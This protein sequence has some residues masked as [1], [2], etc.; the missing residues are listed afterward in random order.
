MLRLP[1]A[2]LPLMH[3]ILRTLVQSFI[4]AAAGVGTAVLGADLS[5]DVLARN[6]WMELTRAD[7]DAVVARVPEDMRFEFSTSPRRVQGVLNNLLVTKTLAAQARAHGTKPAASGGNGPGSDADKALAAGELQRIEADAGK[8]FDAQRPA[9]VAK[10]REI[11]ELDR[12]KYRVPEQVRFSD[13]AVAI[14]DRGDAAALARA[15]EARRRV[16]AGE[17]FAT[18]AQAYSD[19]PTTKDKGGALPLVSRDKL[20]PEL[21][22][23]VFALTTIG[24]VSRPIKAPSAYHV[25]RL[26]ERRAAG[27]RSF[28]E[29]RD[30]ILA[31]LRGK[32]IAEHRDLRIAAIHKDPELQINQPAIDALVTQID[33]QLM[34]QAK[35]PPKFRAPTAK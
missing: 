1:R 12:D 7:Y 4:V 6:R 15:E 2:A 24:E 30:S 22:D 34:Q 5:A 9:F 14:K 16:V 23:G 21:A 29:V 33:P 13:I 18:V 20:T 8:A 17:A 32:Y 31:S 28:D 11:Y 27:V 25:V 26:D 10:A 19:D 35:P 3:R